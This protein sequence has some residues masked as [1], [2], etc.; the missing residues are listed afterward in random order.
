MA[1]QAAVETPIP[2]PPYDTHYVGALEVPDRLVG[3]RL[4][5]RPFRRDDVP[6]LRAAVEES[7]QHIGPWLP[8][9]TG[10]QT[11]AETLDFVAKQRGHWIARESFGA[12]VFLRSNGTLL[13]GA[14]LHPRDWQVPSFEIGYWLRATA[15]GRGYMREAVVLLTRLAF[16]TLA[17]Q[18]VLIRCDARNERSRRVAEA[19]GYTYEGCTRRDTRDSVGGLRDTLHFGLLREEYDAAL[20]GWRALLGSPGHAPGSG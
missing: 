7:R 17:A 3:V 19:C 5:V 12:G 20:P 14:G 16:D 13:G 10:H 2:Q 15:T 6:A 4:V 11:P 8:W 18:R 9:A 1:E